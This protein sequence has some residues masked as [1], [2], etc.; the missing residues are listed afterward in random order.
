M[1]RNDHDPKADLE[2]AEPFEPNMME[3]MMTH[4]SADG[5]TKQFADDRMLG[6]C[7]QFVRTARTDLRTKETGSIF[8]EWSRRRA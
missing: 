2:T 4:N 8:R 7:M 6:V 3:K 1:R 5:A